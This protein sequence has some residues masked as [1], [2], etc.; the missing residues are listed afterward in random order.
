MTRTI[1]L[2]LTIIVPSV[3][4]SATLTVINTNDAGAG[5]LRQAITEANNVFG[6]D[7]IVFNIPTTDPNYNI[8]TGVWTIALL[9]DLPMMTGGYTHID[10]TTQT[11]NQGNTNTFG[12]EIALDGNNTLT[13]AFRIVSPSNTVKGFIL[14]RFDFAIQVYGT[15]ATGNVITQNYIG[16]DATGTSSFSNNHGIGVSGDASAMQVTNNIISGNTTVGIVFSPAKNVT[17]TGN[18]IGTDVSGMLPLS[19]STGIILDNSPNCTIGGT[20]YS[21]RNI[22]S[23]NAD[24]GITINGSGSTGIQVLGN[25]IGTNSNGNDTIPNGNGVMIISA[26]TNT[27]GGTTSGKRNIIS[28]NTQCGVLIN[29]TG[30][31]NNTI[32][33]NYIGTDSIGTAQLGNHYG[34]IIKADANKN[35]VGGNNPTA[36]NIISA[37]WEIGVYIEASDSNI[38]SG[39]YIGTDHT[40]TTTFYIGGDTLTQANG[41]EINTVSKYNLI[42]GSTPGERNIISGNRV[43]GAI[44]YGQVS[45][46]NIAGNYIG[47]DVTGT[48]AIPN[49]T[50]ICVDDASNNNIMEN[51]LLS[52]NIS[53]GLFIVTTGSNYN[54]FRGNFLGTNAAGTDSIPNDVGLLI[55]G[56]AKYNVIGG[57]NPSDRNVFS[58]NHYAGIEVTDNG[59]DYNEIIGNFIGTDISGKVSLANQLGIGI[60]NLSKGTIIENNVIS[61]NKTFGL[62]L[63]DQTDSNIVEGNYI[64][65]ADDGVTDLGNGASGI[66]LSNGAKNNTIGS[67][68]NGNSI[69]YNDSVGIVII[70]NS[71]INNRISANSIFNNNYLGIDILP[72]GVNENDVGDTDSGPNQMMNFPVVTSTGYNSSNGNTFIQ[73]TLDTQ[74]PQGATVEIF[75][76]AP[77]LF[78][79]H[80]EGKVYLGSASP[81]ASGKWTSF[82]TGL[83]NGDDITTTATDENGNTSEFS[84][85][86]TTTVGIKEIESPSLNVSLFPN[87]AN[88]VTSIVYNLEKTT[89]IEIIILDYTGKEILTVFEGN[90]DGGEQNINL[91]LS[92]KLFTSGIYFVRINTD[93]EKQAVLKLSIIK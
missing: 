4:F 53:Y 92:N 56:G 38:V 36:R 58:G 30:A 75:K 10:A 84:L 57:N 91:E 42:G 77:D 66:I 72:V 54:I 62:I 12:P 9:T 59:T 63:T 25:F 93:Y 55:A 88:N 32:I 68:S 8:S 78:F 70:D 89:H 82:V 34:V 73:G 2:F 43:Y 20:S 15:P 61:G 11:T 51:N 13:Y 74:N 29:G 28:G 71:T 23:G 81:D 83:V 47:T 65:L 1:F 24:S 33:G 79:N 40:G 90:Q 87:P 22:I 31:E 80:G 39:N 3:L 50:G 16:T 46:N 19:N 64:G 7:N 67:I 48:Y 52:G 60:A 17:I 14:G 21:A 26:G 35:I 85:N 18:K 49:A 44:Y 69:A 6:P 76:S 5:S 37:N 41:V 27:I 86:T 45:L